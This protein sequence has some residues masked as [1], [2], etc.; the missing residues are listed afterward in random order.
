MTVGEALWTVVLLIER[1]T[2]KKVLRINHKQA[3]DKEI[4]QQLITK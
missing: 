3:K 2:R 4:I 1:N